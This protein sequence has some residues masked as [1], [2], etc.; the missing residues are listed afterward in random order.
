MASS[1]GPGKNNYPEGGG[2]GFCWNVICYGPESYG[3]CSYSPEMGYSSEVFVVSAQ[4]PEMGNFFDAGWV[5][6]QYPE[7]G[8]PPDVGW[9]SSSWSKT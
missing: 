7:N 4:S 6:S 9:T 2:K 1:Q 3:I 8:H 5:I